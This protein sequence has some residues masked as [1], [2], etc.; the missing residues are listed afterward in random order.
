MLTWFREVDQVLRGHATSVEALSEGAIKVSG[1]R[2]VAA[3]VLLAM[4]YGVCL[5]VYGLFNRAEPD[6]RFMLGALVKFPALFLLTLAITFPSLY[7]FNA[8]VG[9]R[10][11]PITLARLMFATLGVTAAMLASLGPIVAFFSV[12]TSS[13]PFMIL[14]NV[15]VCAVAGLFGMR[16]LYQTMHRLTALIYPRDEERVGSVAAPGETPMRAPPLALRSQPADQVRTIFVLWMVVFGLVGAQMS[17][18][19][20]PFLGQPDAEFA[21]FRPRTSNFFESV[22]QVLR[23]LF[24]G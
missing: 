17:W 14:L 19:L 9:S 6:I 23:A 7:V 20:R 10:L 18:I 16:F 4:F 11:S 21:W 15:T 12:T 3:D 5:G 13:Y 2:L 24:G 8:L 22:F 1:R